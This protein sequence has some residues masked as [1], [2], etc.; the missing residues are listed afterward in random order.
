LPAIAEKCFTWSGEST[1]GSQRLAAFFYVQEVRY[2]ESGLSKRQQ[3]GVA[4]DER[5]LFCKWPEK[6]QVRGTQSFSVIRA[7]HG[8]HLSGQRFALLN[9]APGS[10]SCLQRDGFLLRR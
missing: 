9:I 6:M 3:F 2:S 7:I 5:H 4:P 8:A 10:C 1:V